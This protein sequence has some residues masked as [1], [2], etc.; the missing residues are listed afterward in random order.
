MKAVREGLVSKFGLW[1]YKNLY[2]DGGT[3]DLERRLL[4]E[5]EIVF[6]LRFDKKWRKISHR[7]FYKSGGAKEVWAA[8]TGR[9]LWQACRG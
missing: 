9:V 4:A 5:G 3:A 6:V 2:D 8:G 7:D 1:E